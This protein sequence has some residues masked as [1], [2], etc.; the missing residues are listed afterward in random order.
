MENS[1]DFGS[2]H[3]TGWGHRSRNCFTWDGKQGAIQGNPGHKSIVLP[4]PEKSQSHRDGGE[5]LGREM[6]LP[7]LSAMQGTPMDASR[8]PQIP[9]P[10][11]GVPFAWGKKRTKREKKVLDMESQDRG[12]DTKGEEVAM[13]M[14]GRAKKRAQPEARRKQLEPSQKMDWREYPYFRNNC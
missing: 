3:L 2:E 13:S 1:K 10:L 6:S 11:L 8:M 9:L 12:D 14:P 7:L 5:S 4:K